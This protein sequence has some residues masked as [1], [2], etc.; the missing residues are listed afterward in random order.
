M[1]ARHIPMLRVVTGTGT[2]IFAPDY[3]VPGVREAVEAEV[4]AAEEWPSS[5]SGMAYEMYRRN[6]RDAARGER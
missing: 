6:R 5:S 4:D 2:V 1:S 3:S